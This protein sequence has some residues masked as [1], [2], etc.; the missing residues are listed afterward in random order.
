MNKFI[1]KKLGLTLFFGCL[2]MI[3]WFPLSVNAGHIFDTIEGSLQ[4]TRHGQNDSKECG[5]IN[6]FKGS[7][8]QTVSASFQFLGHRHGNSSIDANICVN[9]GGAGQCKPFYCGPNDAYNTNS[10]GYEYGDEH[11][12]NLLPGGSGDILKNGSGSAYITRYARV[13]D[14]EVQVNMSAAAY[15]PDQPS[16][17]NGGWSA[18]SSWSACSVTAC[19]Q[20][21]TQTA[22][23]TCTN[24]T[25]SGGGADCSLLDGG[26]SS[27]TQ[28]CSTPACTGRAKCLGLNQCGW[29]PND[30]GP[31][32]CTID[33]DCG[34]APPP[35]PG[36]TD[37]SATNYNSSA[38]V[39]DGS[40]TYPP[41]PPP[42][43]PPPG[44]FSVTVIKTTGGSIKSTDNL[45]NCGSTC[46][47]Y[48]ASGS[49][50]TL[51]A[52]PSSSYWRFVSWSGDCS[53]TAISCV[54]SVASPKTAT[55]LFSPRSFIY[56]EF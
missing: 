54:L 48:Y 16:P 1:L 29:D 52:I 44:T 46:I 15:Y 3:F 36:C 37:P 25:P 42:P 12:F 53:G 2:V 45:I 43:P 18:W 10:C 7:N 47:N 56:R 30:S 33:S 8:Y 38:T 6:D 23:R 34:G 14:A 17:I 27:K 41:P 28:A 35:V 49:S 19:G 32:Q 9:I 51:Q 21:G 40:C 5:D 11:P 39:N 55:A 22:T 24:P 26:N 13:A 4:C 50:V 31:A 20:T